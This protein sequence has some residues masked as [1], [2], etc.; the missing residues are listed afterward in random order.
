VIDLTSSEGA[1][2]QELVV[3][4]S[5]TRATAWAALFGVFTALASTQAITSHNTTEL[6]LALVFFGG[7][8][9]FFAYRAGRRR[10][11]LMIN[12][13]TLTDGRSGRIVAW[14]SVID[15][16]VGVQRGLFGE[17]HH[18]VLALSNPR[19]TPRRFITTNANNP[20]EIDINLDLLSAPW[21]EVVR[22]VETAS[23]YS[24]ATVHERG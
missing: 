17:A 3:M 16:R 18:L 19:S 20:D 6:V 1:P 9:A 11:V 4:P 5:R 22:F 14:N 2:P 7:P 10:P 24:I 12:A 21:N 8:F 13:H 23:G 15:A